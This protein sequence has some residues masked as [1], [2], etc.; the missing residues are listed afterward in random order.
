[1]PGYSDYRCGVCGEE[2]LRELLAVKEISYK[3][4]G[5]GGKVIQSRVVKWICITNCMPKD[6]DFN[7]PPYKSAPGMKSP[8]LERVK[9]AQA[10]AEARVN[11]A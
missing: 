6:P 1:M 2:T 8:P 7:V 4:M 5:R 9:A 11:Q 3:R 10:A